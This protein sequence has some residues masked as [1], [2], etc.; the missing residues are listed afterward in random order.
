[1]EKDSTI[2]LDR[3]RSELVLLSAYAITCEAKNG[4][5]WLEGLVRSV[6]LANEALAWGTKYQYDEISGQITQA[7]QTS[8]GDV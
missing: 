2:N 5:Q 7:D 4:R 3:C 6:N 8:L 1:M